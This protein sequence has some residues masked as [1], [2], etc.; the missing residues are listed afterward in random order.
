MQICPIWTEFI[1][2]KNVLLFKTCPSVSIF[3]QQWNCWI[4]CHVTWKMRRTEEHSF[5][6]S[7]VKLSIKSPFKLDSFDIFPTMKCVSAWKDWPWLQEW[8]LFR[9]IW[10][11]NSAFL[12]RLLLSRLGQPRSSSSSNNL[13]NLLPLTVILFHTE[14]GEKQQEKTQIC[15]SVSRFVPVWPFYLFSSILVLLCVWPSGL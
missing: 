5:N 7:I 14:G 12:R 10:S 13:T 4:K 1:K 2:K 6:T 8:G 11:L 9:L 15:W 3:S